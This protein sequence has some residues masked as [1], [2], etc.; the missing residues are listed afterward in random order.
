MRRSTNWVCREEAC[1]WAAPSPCWQPC[2]DFY[3]HQSA[4]PLQRTCCLRHST[5][6]ILHHFE[7]VEEAMRL[8]F[9][10][11]QLD[12]DTIFSKPRSRAQDQLDF[13][14]SWASNRPHT[15]AR[16]PSNPLFCG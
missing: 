6:R 3:E 16:F 2:G 9:K 5:T 14:I 8:A 12:H 13:L 1:R 10:D 4:K 7:T 11:N 15:D